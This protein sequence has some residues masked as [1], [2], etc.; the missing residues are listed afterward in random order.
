MALCV[1]DQECS[2]R[3]KK[4]IEDAVKIAEIKR[5]QNP[6]WT[7]IDITEIMKEFF[8]PYVFNTENFLNCFVHNV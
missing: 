3:I 7:F 8:F 1:K 6:Q 4:Y 2:G 5:F